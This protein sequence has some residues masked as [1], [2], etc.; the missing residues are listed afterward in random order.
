M[1]AALHALP[2]ASPAA[3]LQAAA[4]RRLEARGRLG[5]Y[6]LAEVARHNRPED[7]W[8]ACFGKVSEC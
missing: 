7:A 3:R 5:R 4:E 6:T 2:G 8:I 1:T